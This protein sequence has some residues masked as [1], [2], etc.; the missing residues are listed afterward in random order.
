MKYSDVL[1]WQPNT[2]FFWSILPENAK[3]CI[4]SKLSLLKTIHTHHRKEHAL[5]NL[6]VSELFVL[7]SIS[8]QKSPLIGLTFTAQNWSGSGFWIELRDNWDRLPLF[9]H[10]FLRMINQKYCTSLL[11][12]KASSRPRIGLSKTNQP[13]RFSLYDMYH[14]VPPLLFCWLSSFSGLVM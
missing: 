2:C 7:Y 4:T 5:L 6:V 9:C 11:L 3:Q 1:P 13:E 12:A 10:S 8:S 14:S